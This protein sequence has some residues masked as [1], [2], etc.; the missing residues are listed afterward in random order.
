MSR[1]NRMSSGNT[2]PAELFITWSSKH[3]KFVY[4]DKESKS[5][6]MI[7]MPFK[8]LAI[9]KYITITGWNQKNEYSLISNEVKSI[10]DVLT[11]NAYKKGG[12]GKEKI[13][14]GTWKEISELMELKKGK[15]SVRRMFPSCRRT[16]CTAGL[17]Q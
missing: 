11:V 3:E 15:F 9:S 17:R 13:A 5:N 1:V 7:D 6:F 2:N 10:D 12:N 16:I 4:Y 14:E 8:F